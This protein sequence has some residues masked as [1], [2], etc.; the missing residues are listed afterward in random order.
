M[1]FLT[2]ENPSKEDAHDV[3][4]GLYSMF[5]HA[6]QARRRPPDQWRKNYML[7]MNRWGRSPDDPRDS[8]VFP[9]MRARVGWMTDQE[10]AF[11]LNPATD[12][13]SPFAQMEQKLCEHLETVLQSNFHARNWLQQIVMSI[14]D[15]GLYGAGIMK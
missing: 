14:W 2:I 13:F 10:M 1:T 7:A 8:E 4:D 6:V 15:A 11:H 9:I 12:P 3:T 5:P